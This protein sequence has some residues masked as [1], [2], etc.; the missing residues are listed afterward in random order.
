MGA[1]QNT[2]M[3]QALTYRTKIRLHSRTN[4]T[5]EQAITIRLTF[6][7]KRIDLHTGFTIQSSKWDE[8]SQKAVRN[9]T[10]S[11]GHTFADIN[12]GIADRLSTINKIFKKQELDGQYPSP[13][14]VKE[15]YGQVY[16][17]KKIEQAEETLL[18]R[19]DEFIANRSRLNNWSDNTFKKY[20]AIRHHFKEFEEK[21]TIEDL[22]ETKLADL[23]SFFQRKWKHN[24]TLNKR[25]QDI[26]AFFKWCDDGNHPI[27]PAYRTFKPKIKIIRNTVIYLEAEELLR[28]YNYKFSEKDSY[29]DL[30]RDWLCFSSFTSLRFSDVERLEKKDIRK[31][32]FEITTKKDADPV[33]IDLNKYSQAIIKKYQKNPLAGDKVLPPIF[34]QILN[35]NL[36]KIGKLCGIDTPI[37]KTHYQ[38][39]TR[40]ETT[41]PKYDYITAHTGRRTFIC[42]ALS[43]DISPTTVMAWTGHESF[44][45][46]RPYIEITSK[47]KRE[48]MEKFNSLDSLK[49]KKLKAIEEN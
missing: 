2:I 17:N 10:N 6:N 21:L 20:R 31:D 26:R 39:S 40:I 43:M 46:M 23:I 25:L 8:K 13:E 1:N 30:S 49:L 35:A 48:A 33:K 3:A 36:K 38:G 32:Y 34:N 22:T 44:E 19:L 4:S 45:D 42:L 11:Q 18:S 37:T 14:Q 29:L 24:S 7:N 47:A 9:C 12:D 15:E 28:I 5:G 16:S 41:K 27:N